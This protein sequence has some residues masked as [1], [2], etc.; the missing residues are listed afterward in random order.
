[1]H[2][3]SEPVMPIQIVIQVTGSQDDRRI[4]GTLEEHRT[5]V[6]NMKQKLLATGVG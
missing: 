3:C 4:I 1:M 5:S 6:S 2:S